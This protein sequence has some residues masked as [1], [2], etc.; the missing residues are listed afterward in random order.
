MHHLPAFCEEF[1]I[2]NCEVTSGSDDEF[3]IFENL[4][5]QI[6][7]GQFASVIPWLMQQRWDQVSGFANVDLLIH[8]VSGC[9]VD[10]D[11]RNFSAS[12][13]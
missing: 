1:Q 6:P 2:A 9:G 11:A 8:P 7:R 4:G 5:F 13:G 10:I 3:F 12:V